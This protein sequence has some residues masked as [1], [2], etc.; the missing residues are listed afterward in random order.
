[1]SAQP[2]PGAVTLY[3]VAVAMLDDDLGVRPDGHAHVID[4]AP[5]F[6]IA[7]DLP[8]YPPRVPGQNAPHNS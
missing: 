8:Q 6:S 7:D 1:M 2:D 5:W 3:G 4:K